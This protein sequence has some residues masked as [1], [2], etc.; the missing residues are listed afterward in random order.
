MYNPPITAISTDQNQTQAESN[1]IETRTVY[2]PVTYMPTV[3]TTVE[4]N[5]TVEEYGIN[6]INNPLRAHASEFE[7]TRRYHHPQLTKSSEYELKR[8]HHPTHIES[9]EFETT[10]VYQPQ[11]SEYENKQA[12]RPENN[13][14]SDIHINRVYRPMHTKSE[15]IEITEKI[16]K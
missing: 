3:S 13:Q 8:V 7:T 12:H 6:R 16:S 14:S 15:I 1:V 4:T 5:E 11:Y 2:Y 9:S 10:R